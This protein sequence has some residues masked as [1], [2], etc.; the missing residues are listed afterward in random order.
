MHSE[1]FR[2]STNSHSGSTQRAGPTPSRI[3]GV[4]GA[5]AA[6]NDG[7]PGRSIWRT[8]L[9]SPF[10]W[11]KHASWVCGLRETRQ[12]DEVDRLVRQTEA[13][14]WLMAA[15]LSSEHKCWASSDG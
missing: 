13:G 5:E 1:T 4:A 6:Q 11:P 9:M 7:A 15:V 14:F 3:P 10:L 12:R 8:E 2:E